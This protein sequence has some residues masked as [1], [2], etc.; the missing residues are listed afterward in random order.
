MV[1]NMTERIEDETG[2]REERA[3]GNV[4]K[5]SSQRPS[6]SPV[7]ILLLTGALVFVGW[8]GYTTTHTM[9]ELVHAAENAVAM[10][11]KPVR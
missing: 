4:L 2:A 5:T 6:R 3:E 9:N 11:Q 8:L 1:L 7:K 10:L